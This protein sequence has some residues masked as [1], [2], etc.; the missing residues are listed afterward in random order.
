MAE[1][2]AATRSDTDY[3]GRSLSTVTMLAPTTPPRTI[4]SSVT[5]RRVIER[6]SNPSAP[7]PTTDS[8]CSSSRSLSRDAAVRGVDKAQ[9]RK[10]KEDLA[11]SVKRTAIGGGGRRKK[12]ECGSGERRDRRRGKRRSEER[13]ES[14]SRRARRERKRQAEVGSGKI[15]CEREKCKRERGY[16][17]RRGM[18]GRKGRR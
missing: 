18:R 16:P 6:A 15:K 8:R 13:V 5:S 9:R 2:S 4:P 14:I 17:L 10:E 7:V 1:L 11:P 12:T 3:L